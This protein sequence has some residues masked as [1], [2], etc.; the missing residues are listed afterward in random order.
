VH[1]FQS[2]L[3]KLGAEEMLSLVKLE[4]PKP[5]AQAVTICA[6]FEDKRRRTGLESGGVIF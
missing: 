6:R 3:Q 1:F 2:H 5:A 4:N